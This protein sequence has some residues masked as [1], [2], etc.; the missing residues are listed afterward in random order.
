MELQNAHTPRARIVWLSSDD[1]PDEAAAAL[2]DKAGYR[3]VALE[4]ARGADLAV[5]DLR[6]R[7]LSA[8]ALQRIAA[9]IRRAAPECGFVHLAPASLSAS[10]R[11]HL[12]RSGELVIAGGDL[13]GAVEICR[14]RLRLRNLAEETGERLKSAAALARASSF[15]PIETAGAPP[16]TLIAG[17]PGDAALA[18]L[19]AAERVSAETAGAMNAGQAMRSLETGA[20]DCAV[21][22]PKGAGDPLLSLARAMRRHRKLHEI[23][24]IVIPPPGA[25]GGPVEVAWRGA[26]VADVVLRAH[27]SEDLGGRIVLAAR[28]AR[29]AA[30][31]RRFLSAC[32]GEGVRDRLSGA[33]APAFFAQ[34]AERLFARSD[35]TGRPLSLVALRLFPAAPH[36]G[37]RALAE[38]ARL[39]N[40]VTR[41]EDF[42]ARLSPDTFIA[43]LSATGG[44][45]AAVAAKR[46]EGVIANTMFRDGEREKVFAIAAAAGVAERAP[47]A[48]LEEALAGVLGRLSNVRPRAAKS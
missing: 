24:V 22:I 18:A 13:R 21:L 23:P 43:V 5:L 20:F 41:A 10:E 34:H 48:R 15:P 38:A 1:A 9:A 8:K 11:S 36:A 45:D 35:Q 30:A 27:V 33:F 42:V 25:P 28:R 17:A 3:L 14:Q 37:P 6:R 31:M 19:S 7:R 12:R 44:A 46:V 26:N 2:F 47:G 16:R 32:A 4:E 40:R 29:L 39:V